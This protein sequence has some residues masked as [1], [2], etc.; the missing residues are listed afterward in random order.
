MYTIKIDTRKDVFLFEADEIQYSLVDPQKEDYGQ[1]PAH[2]TFGENP[3]SNN[4]I[5]R[6]FYNLFK[7]EPRIFYLTDGRMFVLQNG[8]TV[9]L[10]QV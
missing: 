10:I 1:W 9:D 5:L 6:V 4:F 2:T 7:E 8:K 3:S